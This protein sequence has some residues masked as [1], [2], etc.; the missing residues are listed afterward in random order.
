MKIVVFQ[1]FSEDYRAYAVVDREKC[2]GCGICV[3]ICPFEVPVL[4][5]DGKAEIAHKTC[6]GC[7]ACISPCK[8]KAI[9]MEQ[10]F[11][12]QPYT[13]SNSGPQTGQNSLDRGA[14][15]TGLALRDQAGGEV[16]VVGMGPPQH[17]DTLKD[18]L[19]M[20]ADEAVLL[21]GREF[22]G[23]DGRALAGILQAALKKI[24]GCDLLITPEDERAPEFCLSLAWVAEGLGMSYLPAVRDLELRDGRLLARRPAEREMMEYS[25][26]LPAAITT[27]AA[28]NREPRGLSLMAAAK[29]MQKTVPTYSAADLGLDPTQVGL[30]GSWV[31]LEGV[32]ASPQNK[33]KKRKVKM[34]EGS[35]EE[36]GGALA[37]L[38]EAWGLR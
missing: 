19:A 30:A 22:L 18:A 1:K 6:H 5:G 2:E 24:G 20:D 10:G 36:M 37:E 12:I 32:E 4:S 16:W 31:R 26:A 7:G 8:A 15:E 27:H 38:V 23:S 35:P 9:S 34:L 17:V 25:L 13:G 11:D 3:K 33:A 29:A 21:C 14:I 28:A